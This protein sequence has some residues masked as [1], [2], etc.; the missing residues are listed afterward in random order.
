MDYMYTYLLQQRVGMEL[1]FT[2]GVLHGGQIAHDCGSSRAL[3]YFLE[4]LIALAP[5][6]KHPLS[7]QLTGIT[8]HHVEPSVCF[9]IALTSRFH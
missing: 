9:L 1:D 7:A 3:S 4:I 5:F 8:N 2:P 6:C